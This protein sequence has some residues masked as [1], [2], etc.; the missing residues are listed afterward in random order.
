MR[1]IL[2]LFLVAVLF[3]ACAHSQEYYFG[4]Y[5]T[6][7]TLYQTG[8]YEKAIGKYRE[9][10]NGSPQGNM[11]AIAQYYIGKSYM[12]LNKTVDARTTFQLVVDRYPKTSWAN[13]SKTQ[14]ENLNG[15]AKA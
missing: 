11:A 12:A 15:P 13:F 10:L 7:E 8:K 6:A 14:I 2:G 1:W 9:Y 4:A 5:S 3:S